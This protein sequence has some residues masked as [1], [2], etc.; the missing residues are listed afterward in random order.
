M[1]KKILIN[2][3]PT[4]FFLSAAC[5]SLYIELSTATTKRGANWSYYSI[6]RDDP[7]LIEA[8]ETL[9]LKRAGRAPSKLKI[10]EIPDDV[11][12]WVIVDDDGKECVM[13]RVRR[14][15]D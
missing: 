13:E 9:G 12:D 5:Q 2:T 15:W 7:A 14:M 6:R 8:V 3:V 4:F 10:V 1:P 11:V